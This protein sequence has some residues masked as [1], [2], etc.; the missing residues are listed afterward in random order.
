VCVCVLTPIAVCLCVHR[1][2]HSPIPM[3]AACPSEA[4]G[5]IPPPSPSHIRSLR[6]WKRVGLLAVLSLCQEPFPSCAPTA[7]ETRGSAVGGCWR[8]D[9]FSCKCYPVSLHFVSLL[10]PLPVLAEGKKKEKKKKTTQQRLMSCKMGGVGDRARGE[11]PH[12]LPLGVLVA[13]P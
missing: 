1:V 6:P 8:A 2:S 10:S 5:P 4:G 11:L 13:F 7:P 9:C 12:P 3:Q